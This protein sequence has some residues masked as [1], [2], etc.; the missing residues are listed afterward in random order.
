MTDIQVRKLIER[1]GEQR[2]VQLIEEGF[3][4]RDYLKGRI[5]REKIAR[6]HWDDIIKEER[7]QKINEILK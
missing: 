6:K 7:N 5:D 3:N 1:L 2:I 4:P